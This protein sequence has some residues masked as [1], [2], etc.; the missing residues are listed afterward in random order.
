MI[1]NNHNLMDNSKM[2]KTHKKR[3]K[4]KEEIRLKLIQGVLTI[5]VF[6]VQH[7]EVVL[8]LSQASLLKLPSNLLTRL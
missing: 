7:L 3:A 5:L 4:K 2:D 8:M 1:Q 6:M